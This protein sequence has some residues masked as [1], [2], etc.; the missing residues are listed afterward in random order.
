MSDQV[1]ACTLFETLH[2]NEIDVA[3]LPESNTLWTP[4]TLKKVRAIGTEIYD[5]FKLKGA[6][7]DKP[8][9]TKYQPGG[10]ALMAGGKVVGRSS[11]SGVDKQG[12]GR[13]AYLCLNRE[14]NKRYGS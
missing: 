13:C 14:Q 8:S 9:A 2:K 6:S 7:S 3:I 1:H 12:L 4:E 11:A 5:H 10:V